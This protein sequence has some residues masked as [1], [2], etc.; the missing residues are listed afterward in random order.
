MKYLLLLLL[1]SAISLGQPALKEQS[2]PTIK[3]KMLLPE[4]W[5]LKEQSEDGVTVYQIT[6]EKV[7]NE[8]DIFS[9]GLI[10]SV[11][12]KVPDRASMKPSEYAND[13]L[14]SA[15]DEGEDA[16]LEKTEEGPL[17]CLRV[18][19]TI[20]SDEG[21]IKVIN[22]AKA[23]DSTGTLYFATWQSPEKEETQIKTLREAVLSSIKL[24]PTF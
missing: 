13:L 6:R 15:Q 17:Q 14:T 2:L 18:E 19:Y 10:L 16:K 4:G 1:T 11:T 8:G 5:F 23:N 22:L 21:N 3:G 9:A 7:E 24:D 20:E 12:T